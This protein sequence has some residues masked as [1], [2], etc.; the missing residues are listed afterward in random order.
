MDTNTCKWKQDGF[1]MTEHSY[2]ETTCDNLFRFNTGGP[3][4]NHFKFCP[5]CGKLIEEAKQRGGRNE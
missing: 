1:N 5:Y 3:K 4:Q 2:W